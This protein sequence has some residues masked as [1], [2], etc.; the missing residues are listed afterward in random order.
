M[1][2]MHVL[3]KLVGLW[4]VVAKAKDRREINQRDQYLN[5]SCVGSITE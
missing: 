1:F 3:P 4:Y 2:S 5:Q